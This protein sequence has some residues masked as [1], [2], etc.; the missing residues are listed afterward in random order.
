MSADAPST[1][2]WL[3]LYAGSRNPVFH[4]PAGTVTAGFSTPTLRSP[5]TPPSPGNPPPLFKPRIKFQQHCDPLKVTFHADAPD[6]K[7]NDAQ[8]LR[9]RHLAGGK[10]IGGYTVV[11]LKS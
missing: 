8:V 5:K 10:L 6:L 9:L 3:K 11:L 2:E 7:P 1:M 4:P